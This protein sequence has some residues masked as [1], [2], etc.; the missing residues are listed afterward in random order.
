MN[1][2]SVTKNPSFC[3]I[4]LLLGGKEYLINDR[5]DNIPYSRGIP[6]HLTAGW[7][8]ALGKRWQP[9]GTEAGNSA[10]WAVIHLAMAGMPNFVL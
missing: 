9:G 3:R 5:G 6:L 10:D 8:N 7:E 1:G 2:F 4:S